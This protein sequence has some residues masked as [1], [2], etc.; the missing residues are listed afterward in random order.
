MPCDIGLTYD[1]ATRRCDIAFANGDVVL[2]R[3][4]LTALL[5]AIGSDR[6]ARP[7]DDLPDDGGSP[8]QPTTL[9]AKRGWPGDALHPQQRRIG[10]RLWTLLRAKQT[11]TTR[12]RAE[13]M[14]AE[15]I[16]PVAADWNM[17]AQITVRWVQPGVLGYLVRVGSTAVQLQK[18]LA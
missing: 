14:L 2:D 9:L 5:V 1:P 16:D 17:A 13:T 6:R 8:L 12:R 4:P 7:D 15:A 10:C 3:T 18:A 11:E